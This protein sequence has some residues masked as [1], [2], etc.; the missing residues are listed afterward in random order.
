MRSFDLF[1]SPLGDRENPDKNKIE[2][3]LESTSI[4]WV[5][6]YLQ[7]ERLLSLVL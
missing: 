1:S 7:S 3:S 6:V 4:H 2:F 5:V